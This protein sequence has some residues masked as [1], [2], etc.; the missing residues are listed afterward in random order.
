[1]V[2]VRT[3]SG[4]PAAGGLVRPDVAPA[5]LA[6]GLVIALCVGLIGGAYPALR[7]ARLLPTEALRHE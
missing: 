7:A 6:Q 3:F 2:L 5:V 1:V 4:M